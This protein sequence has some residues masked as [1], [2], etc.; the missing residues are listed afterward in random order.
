MLRNQKFI[1]KSI[2]L[3]II[4]LCFVLLDWNGY[5]YYMFYIPL[6]FLSF[7]GNFY[8]LD[9]NFYLFLLFGLSYSVSD[10][11]YTGHIRYAYNIL[12]VINIPISYLMG[13]YIGKHSSDSETLN[14]LWLF[15][16]SMA[17]FPIASIYFSVA[18]DGFSTINR[19]VALIGYNGSMNGY[20]EISATGLYS[21]LLPITLF[22]CFFLIKKT[23][24]TKW[25]F[26]VTAIIGFI[27]CLRIQS[28]SS[29]YVMALTLFLPMI[30]GNKDSLRTKILGIMIIGLGVRY[31]LMNYANELTIIERFQTNDA[32]DNIGSENR[33]ELALRGLNKIL[34]H[35]F[36]GLKTERY[37]HNLWIDVARVSGWIPSILLFVIAW[38]CIITT[39]HIFRNNTISKDFRIFSFVIT[40]CL[41]LYFNTEPI[42]EGA[43][44]LFIYFCLY[45]GII[46][47][48]KVSMRY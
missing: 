19:D 9:K 17:F 42:L 36:G 7:K 14:I 39:L 25:L 27:C 16:L 45:F 5:G 15:A 30:L 18:Q 34:Y 33:F 10:F 6:L 1:S 13:K 8:K 21:R 47:N 31:I 2:F 46:A 48:K 41:L 28:R 35:P 32:F 38:R 23:T 11:F 20:E 24:N 3:Y 29:V 44:M 22:F 12:P 40:L 37:A 43:P 4:L 26:I